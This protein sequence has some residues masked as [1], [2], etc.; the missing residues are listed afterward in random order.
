MHRQS[1]NN[2]ALI[3]SPAP[4]FNKVNTFIVM[5]NQECKQLFLHSLTVH[6]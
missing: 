5:K 6:F 3:T 4:I 1:L 2:A